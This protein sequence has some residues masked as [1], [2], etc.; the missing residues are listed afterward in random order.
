VRAAK[1]RTTPFPEGAVLSDEGLAYA[2]S[3]GL[4]EEQARDEWEGFAAH[5]KAKGSVFADWNA[6]WQTWVR[7]A[8]RFASER[9]GRSGPVPGAP[10]KHWRA[11]AMQRGLSVLARR[12]EELS[13]NELEAAH[14]DLIHAQAARGD[15][16]A[17]KIVA[18]EQSREIMRRHSQRR[19]REQKAEDAAE[20]ARRDEKGR[21]ACAKFAHEKAKR[22]QKIAH[23]N[24]AGGADAEAKE[25]ERL[26][27]DPAYAAA[28]LAEH[29]WAEY[30][31]QQ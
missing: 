30:A 9:A 10:Q 1:P 16:K 4:S 25:L 21:E 27:R 12:A 14:R 8:I 6:A 17:Q 13:D 5:H 18:A 19:A 11:A 3:K 26:Q 22:L 2:L 23:W 20:A 28:Q 24:A 7:N 29:G 15:W 31:A